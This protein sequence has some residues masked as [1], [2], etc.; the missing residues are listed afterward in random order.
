MSLP[1]NGDNLSEKLSNN[2]ENDLDN[3]EKFE[4]KWVFPKPHEYLGT[5]LRSGT[6]RPLSPTLK[7][8]SPESVIPGL[9]VL[10][11]GVNGIREWKNTIEFVRFF[12][13]KINMFNSQHHWDMRTK[14]LE[15]RLR[16]MD[17]IVEDPDAVYPKH[18]GKFYVRLPPAVQKALK[19]EE[20]KME[21]DGKNVIK[22]VRVMNEDYY[23]R[24]QNRTKKELDDNTEGKLYDKEAHYVEKRHYGKTNAE[25]KSSR[26]DELRKHNIRKH[27]ERIVSSL[28]KEPIS[29][30]NKMIY[31]TGNRKK[32]ENW[33]LQQN[34]CVNSVED[35]TVRKLESSNSFGNKEAFTTSSPEVTLDMLREQWR[36]KK[37]KQE[38]QNAEDEKL[39]RESL[40]KGLNIGIPREIMCAMPGTSREYEHVSCSNDSVQ[41]LNVVGLVKDGLL[42]CGSNS[43]KDCETVNVLSFK[44]ETL[45]CPVKDELVLEDISDKDDVPDGHFP[46]SSTLKL[47]SMRDST[48]LRAVEVTN[49]SVGEVLRHEQNTVERSRPPTRLQRLRRRI[50]NLFPCFARNRVMPVEI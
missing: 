45:S 12:S 8:Y 13:R 7:V 29:K 6:V 18:D 33:I 3:E 11:E 39:K 35:S 9:A 19:E 4:D 28:A 42:D 15:V 30:K 43:N 48:S 21:R 37:E 40:Q 49:D 23:I 36:R 50:R 16:C 1:D 41:D 25:I 10:R 5:V 44:R 38:K 26:R 31:S 2:F 32:I 24:K 34:Y 27:T 14:F 20:M 47:E 17:K 46:T 22:K